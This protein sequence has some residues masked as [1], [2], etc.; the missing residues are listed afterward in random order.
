MK[1]KVLCWNI[2]C[3]AYLDDVIDFLRS[4]DADIIALQEACI[5]DRG[6]IAEIIAGKL[7]YEYMDAIGMDMPVK[8][9]HGFAND[10]TTVIKFGTALLT[11][12][13]IIESNIIKITDMSNRLISEARIDINGNIFNVF[14]VHFNHT[15]QTQSELQDTQAKNLAQ[16]ANKDHTIVMGDFNSLPESSVINEMKSVLND[17]DGV[18]SKPTWCVYKDG[19]SVCLIDEIKYKLDYIFTS[20]DLKS[21]SFEVHNSQ[22]SDHLPISAIISI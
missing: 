10:D 1:V 17:S 3:G 7:G 18:E 14:S 12:H 21:S 19:C 22:A 15:H 2:W 13:K 8:F 5:D 11:K 9:L 16:L 4:A 20:Q 6:N